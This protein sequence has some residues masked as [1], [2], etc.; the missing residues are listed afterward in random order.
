MALWLTHPKYVPV[1]EQLI[2]RLSSRWYRFRK[3]DPVLFL[4]GGNKSPRRETL[5]N[6]LR[7]T[8]PNL[9][10]FYAERVW[11]HIA[12]RANA[13]ALKMEADLAGLADLVVIV[14]ESPGT[15]AELGAFSL[16]DRLRKK[17]VAIIDDDY[18]KDPSF[19]NTGPVQ[20]LNQ[21]SDFKPMIYGPLDRIL[22]T[23]DQIEERIQRIR[24]PRSVAIPDLSSSRKHLL[25][26]LC[27]L[28][29]VIHPAT[30]EIVNYYLERIAPKLSG[31]E[32]VH[33]LIGVAE[34]M[35]L[36]AARTINSGEKPQVFFSPA[37]HD[38]LERPFHEDPR[39]DLQSQR[40]AH[41]AVLQSVDQ[42][43]AVLHQLRRVS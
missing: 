5:R 12:S 18:R 15:F 9:N 30:V 33:T 31:A 36:L 19:I 8:K 24:S 7:K 37:A 2:E 3:V 43:K 32:D 6:Y 23:V 14:V 27:D 10:V 4:C 25:Y 35:G 11:E 38:A 41:V 22:E 13:G 1:R 21:E 40:A 39:L 26:F 29:A 28:I 17:I 34:A 16:S 20:W 42:A